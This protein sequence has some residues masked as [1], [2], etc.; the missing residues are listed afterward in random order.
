[1]SKS[2]DAAKRFLRE[3]DRYE[4]A[5]LL[6]LAT[7]VTSFEAN[8]VGTHECTVEVFTPSPF[9]DALNSLNDS[10]KKR[11]LEAVS[12]TDD[13]LQT[14][15]TPAEHIKF[16]LKPGPELQPHQTLIADVICQRNVMI[17]VAT[18][19][20]RI[21]DVN[22]YYR[23]RRRRI[24]GVLQTLGLEDPNPH[25]D[26]WHWYHHWSAEFAHYTERRRYVAGLYRNLLEQ[27]CVKPPQPSPA[28]ELTGWE[29]V[30]RALA[31]ARAAM[32][33]AK[34]EEDFQSI[35]LLCREV[36]ISLG[37]AVYDP[38]LHKS[39]DGVEPSSTDGRRMIEAYVV[40]EFSGPE[41]GAI[42][43]HAKAT[44]ELA[45][46]LQHKRTAA[47]RIAALCLEATSSIVSQVAILSGRRD[48]GTTA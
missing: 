38:A 30:D 29:R 23:A 20:R 27:L 10:E 36:V 11:I 15:E 32:E 47:F 3:L 17:E 26:L 22:D 34:H 13:E 14:H 19:N 9:H 45:V 39:P 5:A 4:L 2:L 48:P 7:Y 35:G 42:R 25:E 24:R 18:T 43:K 28:R 44:L 16:L 41:N 21:A 40:H 46:E 8:W 37:Q 31:K 33:T 6:E 12:K 1:M